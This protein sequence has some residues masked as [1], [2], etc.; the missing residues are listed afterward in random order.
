ML[1][2][3]IALGVYYN[4]LHRLV[5]CCNNT[6]YND[7]SCYCNDLF[8]CIKFFFSCS[9][10]H[11]VTAWIIIIFLKIHNMIVTMYIPNHTMKVKKIIFYVKHSIFEC[12]LCKKPDSYEILN[13][14]LKC[15]GWLWLTGIV[16]ARRVVIFG[17]WCMMA[18]YVYMMVKRLEKKPNSFRH[19][20]WKLLIYYHRAYC[21]IC[22]EKEEGNKRLNKSRYTCRWAALGLEC[23]SLPKIKL[24]IFLLHGKYTITK[25]R[26]FFFF[27]F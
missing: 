21:G 4:G 1:H 25:S 16:C 23:I 27:F 24:G 3:P 10:S 13:L 7:I 20:A 2:K 9:V 11:C 8:C 19:R 6:N 22:G 26:Q 18:K 17:V 15:E 12:S 14:N 5:Y